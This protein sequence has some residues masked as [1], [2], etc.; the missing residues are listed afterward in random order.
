MKEDSWHT[1]VPSTPTRRLNVRSR[2]KM[3][4]LMLEHGWSV[5]ATAER[6]QVDPKTAR[7]WRGRYLAEGDAGL[8]DR[9][10][11]PRR[12][13]DA[14]RAEVLDLR[15]RRCW[16]AARI[17]SEVGLAASTVQK[18]L[19]SEGV[20]R[21]DTGDRATQQPQRYVR[22]TPGELVH[23]DVNK[24]A[25]IPDGGGH[26][27]HGRGNAGP[28]QRAGYVFIHSALND[29]SRLTYSEILTDET[30]DTAAGF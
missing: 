2:R 21:L 23:V 1:L 6:F 13:G 11:C 20:G 26:R 7:K 18:I 9:S 12:T 3:V 15:R 24:L 30:G 5:A 27:A 29:N 28:R 4:E 17:A 19:D 14:K 22:E 16:G 8:M 25:A 10:R